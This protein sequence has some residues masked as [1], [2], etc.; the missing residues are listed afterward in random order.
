[1]KQGKRFLM[2]LMSVFLLSCGQ[3]TTENAVTQTEAPEVSPSAVPQTQKGGE[4]MRIQVEGNGTT[5]LFALNDS[6]AAKDLVAR[7]P[8]SIAV[9]NFSNNE[10]IFYPSSELDVNGAPLAEGGAGTLAYYA[11]W[12]DVVM[13]Y[14]NFNSNGSL[15]ALGEAVSGTETIA[16]LSGTI[17]I[18]VVE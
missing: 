16:N 15:Y 10:K 17:E 18:R 12:G 7:L 13:F 11:P 3:E 8:M 1:M 6:Q 14:G 2:A 4:T 9:E 5:I